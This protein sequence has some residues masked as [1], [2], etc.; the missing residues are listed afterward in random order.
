[1]NKELNKLITQRV[2]LLNRLNKVSF[3]SEDGDDDDVT[4][5]ITAPEEEDSTQGDSESYVELIPIDFDFDID[6][7]TSFDIYIT[8]RFFWND[9]KA[10]YT[11]VF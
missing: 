9:W 3:Y 8:L 11:E 2:A 1:M 7:K 4:F 6:D 5:V 10:L